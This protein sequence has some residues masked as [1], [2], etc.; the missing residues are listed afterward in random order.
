MTPS[1]ESLASA[2]RQSDT[3]DRLTNVTH[4]AVE[5]VHAVEPDASGS[6]PNAGDEGHLRRTKRP[7]SGNRDRE[8]PPSM[9]VDAEIRYR[10]PPDPGAR[11]VDPTTTRISPP[12]SDA[13]TVFDRE[14][15]IAPRPDHQRRALPRVEDAFASV[16]EPAPS[17]LAASGSTREMGVETRLAGVLYLLN[18][19]RWLDLPRCFEDACRLA[20]RV[21]GWGLLEALARALLGRL[22]EAFSDDPV[23]EL[24]AELDLRL[25]GEAPGTRFVGNDAFRLPPAWLVGLV[26]NAEPWRAASDA[27]RLRVWSGGGF[28]LLDVP[29]EGLRME[30]Q[31]RAE[32]ARYAALGVSQCIVGRSAEDAPFVEIDIAQAPA[33]TPALTRWLELAMPYMTW[34]LARAL[35]VATADRERLAHALLIHPGRLFASAS[36]VDLVSGLGDVSLPVRYAGLDRDPGWLPQFSR[37]V[38]FHFE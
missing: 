5:T 24:L 10:P 35:A 18:V 12:T 38:Q 22:G 8:L 28:L 4:D 17:A 13:S 11:A 19:M 1:R 30:D 3:D 26:S 9:G 31:A 27:G 37:V 16:P 20:S 2:S 34:R 29:E 7:A 32:L 23:W 21:G 36:H 33:L 15:R 25:P 6:L 14:P